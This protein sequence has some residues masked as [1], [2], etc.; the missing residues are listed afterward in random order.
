MKTRVFVLLA[1]QLVAGTV[2]AADAQK[3]VIGAH[4]YCGLFAVLLQTLNTLDW[5][6]RTGKVP[7]VYWDNLPYAQRGGYRGETNVWH[8]Y[9]Q[10]V[11]NLAYQKGDSIYRHYATPDSSPCPEGEKTY[12][13]KF[14]TGLRL[15][16]HEIIKK[17]VR[18][19]PRINRK[20]WDFYVANMSGKQL[21]GIHLRGTDKHVDAI[22]IDPAIIFKA[23]QELA[24]TLGGNC[25]FFVASD[26]Y[27]LITLAQQHLGHDRVIYYD[28]QRSTNGSPVH[29]TKGNALVGEQVLIEAQLLS[30]CDY[31]LH[32][33]SNVAT[34]VLLFNPKLKSIFFHQDKDKGL[35]V[36]PHLD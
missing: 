32:T 12:D 10:P 31:F 1:M 8:Y 21:I 36:R 33:M 13:E 25:K 7:V 6:N 17:N 11:S 19:Q 23:A 16:Y 9:F 15:Y 30:K 24:A 18:L 28:A 35:I 27:R 26:E 22:P 4:C 5:A 34:G 29:L 20:M 2:R 3:F 14:H